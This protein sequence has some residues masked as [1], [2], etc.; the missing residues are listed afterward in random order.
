[1]VNVLA[2]GPMV[3]GFRP[4]R[5]KGFLRVIRISS[6]SSFGGE[7]KLSAHIVRFYGILKNLS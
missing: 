3:G 1:M 2:N 6:T 7:V 5:G 4:G